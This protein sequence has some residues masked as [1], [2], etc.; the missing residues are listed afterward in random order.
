[1]GFCGWET[2]NIWNGTPHLG[3]YGFHACMEYHVMRN[4]Y[5]QLYVTYC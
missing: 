4:G 1:M 5:E 2:I 3:N